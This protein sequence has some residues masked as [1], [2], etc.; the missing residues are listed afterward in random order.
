M[1][2]YVFNNK[3][4]SITFKEHLHNTQTSVMKR[5]FFLLLSAAICHSAA[6]HTM[7]TD[8]T[9]QP[10]RLKEKSLT[11]E[12]LI[13]SGHM[14]NSKRLSAQQLAALSV[15]KMDKSFDPKLHYKLIDTLYKSKTHMVVLIGQWYDFENKAWIASYA[16]PNK[17]IDYKLVF[18]DNAEGF[19][20]VETSI[21]QNIITITTIKEFEEEGTQKKKETF[22]L[23]AN[24]KLQKL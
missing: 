11:A 17:L 3:K 14:A 15:K 24:F 5:L 13:A 20:S 8:T 9:L 6:A 12:T 4:E 22:R 18:Y 21:K 23:G 1:P 16:A 2:A 7:A 10:P 19:L